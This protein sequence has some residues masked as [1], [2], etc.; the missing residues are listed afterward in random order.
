MAQAAARAAIEVE[1]GDAPVSF[2]HRQAPSQRT[3]HAPDTRPKRRRHT[4][5]AFQKATMS[6]VGPVGSVV[7]GAP[8]HVWVCAVV[9]LLRPGLFPFTL[10]PFAN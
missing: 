9:T 6:A 3:G 2:P 8:V 7:V 10:M 5:Q 1:T 4:S